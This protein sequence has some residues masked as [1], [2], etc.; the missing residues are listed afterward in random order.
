MARAKPSKPTDYGFNQEAM[1]Q[2][3]NSNIKVVIDRYEKGR[4]ARRDFS[5]FDQ[6]ATNGKMVGTVVYPPTLTK[7]MAVAGNNMFALYATW[8]GLAGA[9]DNDDV[10]FVQ[11]SR[12]EPEL[13]TDRMRIAGEHFRKIVNAMEPKNAALLVSLVHDMLVSD[14]A[15]L[16]TERA[17]D[18]EVIPTEV[19]TRRRRAEPYEWADIDGYLTFR[20]ERAADNPAKPTVRWRKVVQL[21]SGI[22]DRDCQRDAI[23]R[24][25]EDLAKVMGC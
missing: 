13:F 15:M 21:V 14:G 25:C 17:P 19:F 18:P 12:S 10:G 6:L 8:K 11:T 9:P 20:V 23:K 16:V 2:P 5:V 4:V 3:V 22:N 7:N 1:N 24:M